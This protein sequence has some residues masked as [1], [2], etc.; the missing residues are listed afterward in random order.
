M[1]QQ[2]REEGEPDVEDQTDADS[3]SFYQRFRTRVQQFYRTSPPPTNPTPTPPPQ[4]STSSFPN[5]T[6]Q[7]LIPPS[8][9]T[10]NDQM[11]SEPI[12][13]PNAST[14]R[15]MPDSSASPTLSMSAASPT[16]SMSATNSDLI[17]MADYTNSGK[18]MYSIY[19]EPEE[20]INETILID[21]HIPPLEDVIL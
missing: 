5:P 21:P 9:S 2:D 20:E 14:C 13:P 11:D 6:Y 4:P 10:P 8:T 18:Y 3:S 7:P 19:F 1:Q 17:N 15:Y 16:L 12:T